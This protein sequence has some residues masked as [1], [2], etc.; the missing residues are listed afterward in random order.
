MSAISRPRVTSEPVPPAPA[1]PP[2]DALLRQRCWHAEVPDWTDSALQQLYGN[3]YA[4]LTQFHLSRSMV[5]AST[6]AAYQGN[7]LKT[8]L[9]FNVQHGVV[10]VFNEVICLSVAEIEAFAEHVFAIVA[11]ARVVQL[12]A[13]HVG[14]AAWRYPSQHYDYLEDTWIALPASADAYTASLSK[15]TRR[16]VRRYGQQLTEDFPGYAFA[17]AEE[18]QADPDQIDAIIALNRARMANKS[19]LSAIDA[20]ETAR[21]KQLAG[22][23]GLVGVITIDGKVCAGAISYHV[24]TNHFL[25]VLAHDPAYDRYSLGFLCCYLTICACIERGGKEFHFLW[26]RYDYKRQ[27]LGQ[28]RSLDHILLYRSRLAR[29]RHGGLA[30]RAWLTASRRRSMLALQQ[31]SRSEHRAARWA[32]QCYSL[33]RRLRHAA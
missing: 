3:L 21:L 20:R 16:N 2:V 23:C 15:N 24:G 7:V 4:S 29:W 13:V 26:G 14:P 6:Y 1:A 19:K 17:L 30:L 27:F 32:L 8:L 33:L 5:Q 31:A 18:G 28:Q 10:T 12:R 22:S 9:V 11:E 25:V